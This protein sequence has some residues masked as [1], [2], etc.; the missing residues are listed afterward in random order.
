MEE[1]IPPPFTIALRRVE[2]GTRK[3]WDQRWSIS[4]NCRQTKLWM[5]LTNKV[6]ASKLVNLDR[7]SLSLAVHLLSGH[8]YL[9]YHESLMDHEVP[10]YCREGCDSMETAWHVI[11]ECPATWKLRAEVFKTYQSLETPL[12]WSVY[13]INKIVS[14]PQV[15]NLLEERQEQMGT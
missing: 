15:I 14:N 4:D 5:P 2:S 12:E 7:K 3:L 1:E 11:C 9:R 8:N 6:K 10:P 13:Q